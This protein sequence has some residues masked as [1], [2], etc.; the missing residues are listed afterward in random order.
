MALAPLLLLLLVTWIV[1]AQSQ[2]TVVMLAT[3]SL[4]NAESVVLN[5]SYTYQV[6]AMPIVFSRSIGPIVVDGRGST[7]LC[8]RITSHCFDSAIDSLITLRNLTIVLQNLSGPDNGRRIWHG[9]GRARI[10]LENVIVEA[11][12]ASLIRFGADSSVELSVTNA[13]M[14]LGLVFATGG[15]P[16]S[17]A[18]T[19]AFERVQLTCSLR[20]S[21]INFAGG[22]RSSV[23][24]EDTRVRPDDAAATIDSKNATVDFENATLNSNVRLVGIGALHWKA[25]TLGSDSTLTVSGFTTAFVDEL[26]SSGCPQMRP[27]VA[28]FADG[29]SVVMQNTDLQG[30]CVG[31]VAFEFANVT[32]V[33]LREVK[34][35]RLTGALVK[36]RNAVTALFD[37][38][39]FKDVDTLRPDG[40]LHVATGELRAA[41]NAT[42]R[43]T[44]FRNVAA[45]G[46]VLHF[47]RASV[48][49]DTGLFYDCRSSPTL[50]VVGRFSNVN[51]MG[52]AS[53][54]ACEW[55]FQCGVFDNNTGTTPLLTFTNSGGVPAAVSINSVIFQ[56]NRAE[57]LVKTNGT[58]E[59]VQ[60]VGVTAT[61][62]VFACSP[63]DATCPTKCACAA[64]A[65]GLALIDGALPAAG[66]AS[67]CNN[68]AAGAQASPVCSN[69]QCSPPAIPAPICPRSTEVCA[70][71]TWP[72]TTTQARSTAASA[73]IGITTTTTTT[74]AGATT[75]T[76]TT[77]AATSDKIAVVGEPAG[78][79][80]ASGALIGGVVGGVA[81]L[82]L[83]LLGVAAL[84]RAKKKQQQ[85][86]APSSQYGSAPTLSDTYGDST[87]ANLS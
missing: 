7:I 2:T 12:N 51:A 37:A 8:S 72:P 34:L 33:T 38:C 9:T 87:L 52:N 84:V 67:F 79:S 14:Q 42:I 50:P 63:C 10:A 18:V 40:A 71:F 1:A 60:I 32:S 69:P 16:V 48:F 49:V 43:R 61:K 29:D 82:L 21:C 56:E 59:Q 70:I 80:G 45:R 55:A 15:V 35:E 78:S 75:R 85:S 28:S 5:S 11:A 39:F 73:S 77:D 76:T 27:F 62:N 22:Q 66:F 24:L 41:T 3:S 31:D 74:T 30:A 13:T 17:T 19:V 6:D 36:V 58:F 86:A 81:A 4:F 23:R 54:V 57:A 53:S 68:S 25:S 44:L 83:V 46:S 65:L 26:R 20:P 64:C 47:E